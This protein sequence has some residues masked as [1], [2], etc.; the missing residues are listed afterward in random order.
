[1]ELK[2]V[3]FPLMKNNIL[4]EDLDAVISY[5]QQEDPILTNNA[6]VKEFEKEWSRWLGVKYSVFVNSGSSA[7]FLSMVL[8]KE[9]FPDG[10]EVIVPPLTWNS[11][12]V[13]VI[14]AGFKPIFCDIRRDTLG[15]DNSEILKKITDK[16]RAVFITHAQGFNALSDEL[17]SVL[18]EKDIVLIEDVCESH[19]AC[20]GEK[21]LGTFGWLSNFSF[22]YA[23]HM[24]TIEGGMIC[25]NDEYAYESLRMSRSHG[26]LRECSSQQL[27]ESVEK[28]NPEL[29]PEFIF[30]RMGFNMRNTELGAIIG[31]NQLPR[32]SENIQIRTR[33]LKTFLKLLNPEKFQTKFRIEGSSNYAFNLILKNQDY[34]FANN[35]IKTL[36]SKGIEFRRGS[37]GG[38]N[39]LRQP[40][41]K[42]YVLKDEYKNFP[43]T[44]HIHFFGFYLGNYPDMTVQD[45]EQLVSIINQVK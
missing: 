20:H 28:E 41:L 26:L 19:G 6:K 29:N 30:T 18:K 10:G 3:N 21:K 2:L 11:D 7:N 31:L 44:E 34:E 17:L 32:L 16:T 45:V 25:T 33:N 22:Y 8:L 15:L 42:G 27:R 24:S 36:T 4:R 35:L 23:H 40:Y 12:I 9:K 14:C 1:M 38:G 43:V 37:A 13:S 39:Q 5:L